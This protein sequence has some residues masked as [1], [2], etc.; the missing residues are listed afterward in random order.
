MPAFPEKESSLLNKLYETAPW[1]AKLHQESTAPQPT[2]QP[3]VVNGVSE[4]VLNIGQP[5]DTL[6]STSE[7]V[8]QSTKLLPVC[9]I[10]AGVS[11]SAPAPVSTSAPA[12]PVAAPVADGGLLVNVLG[13]FDVAS[14][15]QDSLTPGAEEGYRKFLMKNNGVLFENDTLQIGVKSE[16]KKNLGIFFGQ[17]FFG[18]TH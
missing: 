8:W 1:T 3:P 12:A 14:T 11:P 10:F 2:E 7:W 15:A 18:R 13:D 9:G 17:S 5:M 6:I 4:P 16:Y